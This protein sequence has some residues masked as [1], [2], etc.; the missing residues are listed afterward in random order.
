[1]SPSLLSLVPGDAKHSTQVS[2]LILL[3][4]SLECAAWDPYFDLG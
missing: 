1:M 4:S 2:Q 3:N